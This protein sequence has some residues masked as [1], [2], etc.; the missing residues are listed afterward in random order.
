MTYSAPWVWVT[1]KHNET[2]GQISKRLK[3]I[4]HE[5]ALIWRFL[6]NRDGFIE[7]NFAYPSEM[8]WRDQITI[9]DIYHP[10]DTFFG[11]PAMA[12][13][14]SKNLV[15][16]RERTVHATRSLTGQ[17]AI[18]FLHGHNIA[19]LACTFTLTQVKYTESSIGYS[20]G[21]S[22]RRLSWICE[23]VISVTAHRFGV[24]TQI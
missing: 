2:T 17:Q 24:G 16:V 20:S 7:N 4:C 8:L 18:A 9:T 19:H 22:G 12:L 3:P 11:I 15:Q 5:E 23:R 1:K 14:F 6:A 13:C 10:I 21:Q